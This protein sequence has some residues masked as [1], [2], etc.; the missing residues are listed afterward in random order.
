MEIMFSYNFAHRKT[1]DCGL[2]GVHDNFIFRHEI[3]QTNLIW[4]L[5]T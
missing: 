4:N 3:L 2:C 5:F 1:I